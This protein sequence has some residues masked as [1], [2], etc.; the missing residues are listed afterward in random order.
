M[1]EGLFTQLKSSCKASPDQQDFRSLFLAEQEKINALSDRRGRRWHPLV[2]RWCFQLYSTSPKAYQQLKDSGILTLPDSRTLRDYSNC[3]KSGLG[4]DPSFL[5]LVKKDYLERSDPKDSDS[6]LGL[7]HDEVSIRKDLVFDD[8]GKLIGFVD[9]GST[10]NNIDELERSLSSQGSSTIPEEATHM[11][12]FMAV[13]LFSNWK[14][15]VAFFPTTTIKSYALFNIFWKCIEELE[16]RD[17]KVLT[18]TCDGASPHR[19][20]YRFHC[21]P[22]APKGTLI[23]KTNNV[24][25]RETR[26]IYFICDPVHLLKTTRNNWENSFWRNKT[27]KLRNNNMWITWLQLIDA[28]ENDIN[29]SNASGLRLL[30]KLTADHLFLNPYLRMRVYLAAQVFSNRVAN[31]ITIQGKR[32]TEETAK[33]VRNMNDFFDCL[34]ANRVFTQFEFKSVYRSPHDRRLVWLEGEFLKYFQDWKNW[35]MNQTDVPLQERKQYFLSD[36]TWEGLQICVKSFVEVVRFSL[37][38]LEVDYV[39]ATKINQ[40]PLEKFFGK[41]RQKRG[42]YGTFTC[43]EFSQSYAS[44]V[45][46]QTHA[47]KTVRR[48]KRTGAELLPLEPTLQLTKVHRVQ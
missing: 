32:G 15:P 25:A 39:V 38:I 44:A 17:F 30:H 21:P 36:Q 18:S 19:K 28:F 22:G 29:E 6:W 1:L 7:I 23:F 33:F 5:D 26:P 31:A 16:Q 4:F 13:S 24:Y 2:I 10:Q 43:N 40:D 34:N 41:L 47:I 14:M 46:A 9:L 45:F 8:T 12:V 3:Y 27:R 42:A 35:A 37:S 48:I 11:F 20:F